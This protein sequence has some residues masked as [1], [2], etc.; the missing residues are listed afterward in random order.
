VQLDIESAELDEPID[1][2]VS[3][4]GEIYAVGHGALAMAIIVH[5]SRRASRD[6]VTAAK[7]TANFA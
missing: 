4:V 2:V 3:G 5:V 7:E 6:L 1:R